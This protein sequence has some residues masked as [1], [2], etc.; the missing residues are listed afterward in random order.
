M[1]KRMG[2]PRR[3]VASLPSFFRSSYYRRIDRCLLQ[4]YIALTQTST[5]IEQGTLGIASSASN[6]PPWMA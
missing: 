6:G 2:W 1:G 3:G 5:R 4:S